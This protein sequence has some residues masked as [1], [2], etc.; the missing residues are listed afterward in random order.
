MIYHSYR[1]ILEDHFVRQ[2]RI[3]FA[4]LATRKQIG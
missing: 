3:A 2:V 1:R 4:V